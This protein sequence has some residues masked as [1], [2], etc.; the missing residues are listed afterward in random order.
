M[1]G[2]DV[3]MAD[4]GKPAA[5]AAD[6]KPAEAEAPKE[7]DPLTQ[8]S[9]ALRASQTQLP[10]RAPACADDLRCVC[11]QLK[12]NVVLLERGVS[13]KETRFTARALRQARW[14]S[15]APLPM[16]PARRL[17]PCAPGRLLHAQTR[18]PLTQTTSGRKKLDAATVAEFIKAR[19]RSAHERR[20]G[21]QP[22]AGGRAAL[23]P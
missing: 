21:A 8:V 22:G 14:Q 12:R 10:Q 23:E 6:A 1:T 16:P 18:A 13:T 15:L 19:T 11:A 5:A 20:R 4:A 9:P 2:K 17:P 3:D 7:V